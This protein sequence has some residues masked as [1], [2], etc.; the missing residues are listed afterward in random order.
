MARGGGR[1]RATGRGGI[2]RDRG[3]RFN[4]KGGFDNRR[5]RYNDARLS[6]RRGDGNWRDNPQ[7]RPAPRTTP[8]QKMSNQREQI[9]AVKQEDWLL[10]KVT[11]PFPSAEG[12]IFNMLQGAQS[13]ADILNPSFLATKHTHLNC[14][15]YNRSGRWLSF[16]GASLSEA[17]S[18]CRKYVPSS[19]ETENGNLAK[20]GLIEFKD[21][22]ESEAGMDFESAMNHLNNATD[23]ARTVDSLAEATMAFFEAVSDRSNTGSFQRMASFSYKMFLGSMAMLEAKGV[24]ENREHLADELL[25]QIHSMPKEVKSFVQ[26]PQDDELFMSA[27]VACYMEQVEN[28][29]GSKRSRYTLSDEEQEQ[30]SDEGIIE[31]DDMNTR[32]E[33]DDDPLASM[34]GPRVAEARPRLFGGNRGGASASPNLFGRARGD[35]VY[36]DR[37][38]AGG[39]FFGV[40]KRD[41]APQKLPSWN[42]PSPAETANVPKEVDYTQ[43]TIL[44]LRDFMNELQGQAT[45][46]DMA[47]LEATRMKELIDKIPKPL[48]Q[49]HGLPLSS[50]DFAVAIANAE[51]MSTKVLNLV[52]KVKEAWASRRQVT[53]HKSAKF[54]IE[55]HLE[56]HGLVKILAADENYL[57]QKEEILEAVAT[58]EK[59]DATEEDKQNAASFQ[60]RVLQNQVMDAAS[61]A[62]NWA[63][64][65]TFAQ[66]HR[67]QEPSLEQVVEFFE[68]IEDDLR[69]ALQMDDKSKYKMMIKPKCW[70]KDVS[71]WFSTC[72]LAFIADS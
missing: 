42:R 63:R 62:H 8:F 21:F 46:A 68:P 67:T 29:Q 56:G 27:M 37:N 5:D 4:K 71:R 69:K 44:M 57:I 43:W 20:T 64:A 31:D 66:N 41:A 25:Q 10:K 33:M 50:E 55:G 23:T 61:A 60:K 47:K 38:I 65:V 2:S 72:Y 35:A 1:F 58:A 45:A 40:A 59:E 22:L 16:T 9:P 34:R 49:A 13:D 3:N 17:A 53:E 19:S 24:L 32:I 11:R 26:Q 70:R 14:E 39:K 30:Y 7:R 52:G 6:D 15:A 12:N 51:A 54:G 28:Q 48:R 18:Y 36:V